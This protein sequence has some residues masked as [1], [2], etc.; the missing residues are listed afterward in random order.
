MVLISTDSSMF[1]R[2]SQLNKKDRIRFKVKK[3]LHSI[4]HTLE[5][6]AANHWNLII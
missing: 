6:E 2:T 3:V 1:N 5:N 4:V